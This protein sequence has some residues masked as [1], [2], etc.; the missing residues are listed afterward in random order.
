MISKKKGTAVAD[1]APG[2]PPSS[3]PGNGTARADADL[4]AEPA[5]TL[6]GIGQVAGRLGVSERTLRYYEEIGLIIPLDRVPGHARRYDEAV[7]ARVARIV[8]LRELMG[9]NLEEIRS[10]LVNEDRLHTL[11]EEYHSGK[12]DSARNADLLAESLALQEDLRDKVVAKARHL[13][14]FLAELD[15]RISRTRKAAGLTEPE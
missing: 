6:L 3:A 7:V 4:R 14:D 9:F 2:R 12:T 10:I 1:P 5:E 11:R 15:G 13:E 8:E